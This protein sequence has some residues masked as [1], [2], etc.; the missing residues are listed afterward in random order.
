M[1]PITFLKLNNGNLIDDILHDDCTSC[2]IF[3][4]TKRMKFLITVHARIY[5]FFF[6][7][8]LS[9]S[10]RTILRAITRYF[11]DHPFTVRNITVRLDKIIFSSGLWVV[12]T[13]D[14]YCRKR[15]ECRKLYSSF[16]LWKKNKTTL[17]VEWIVNIRCIDDG[18]LPDFEKIIMELDL[19]NYF[20]S[21]IFIS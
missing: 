6:L 17:Y 1:C 15:K 8:F 16:S 13:N 11:T 5:F 4:S 18:L 12:R 14:L 21:E 20:I 3:I 2:K 19:D 7:S 10:L 9:R